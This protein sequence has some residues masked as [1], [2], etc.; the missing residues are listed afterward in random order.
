MPEADN[1]GFADTAGSTSFCTGA[2]VAP[3]AHLAT[4][5]QSWATPLAVLVAVIG[6]LTALA[7][8][9]QGSGLGLGREHGPEAGWVS[10]LQRLKTS[11][12]ISFLAWRVGGLLGIVESLWLQHTYD[13][14]GD[15][16]GL[17]L[18]PTSFVRDV[19][20][21]LFIDL[22]QLLFFWVVLRM[23]MTS[24][25]GVAALSGLSKQ[26]FGEVLRA[27]IKW[28]VLLSIT[29]LLPLLSTLY[30]ITFG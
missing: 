24:L 6:T 5:F 19:Y 16:N 13:L 14:S 30:S 1:A 17:P 29:L 8:L 22:V 7:G 25:H 3:C 20:V 23:L 9:F 26:T 11:L 12:L 28:L 21:V 27:Q 4:L 2:R 15:A 10:F 18:P